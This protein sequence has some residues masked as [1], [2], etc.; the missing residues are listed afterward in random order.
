[1]RNRYLDSDITRL[2]QYKFESQYYHKKE[3]K[4]QLTNEGI[5]FFVG[6]ISGHLPWTSVNS[7]EIINEYLY[8]NTNLI[9][10]LI[11]ARAFIKRED[12][13]K[14]HDYIS[15]KLVEFEKEPKR[16]T[17]ISPKIINYPIFILISLL[18]IPIVGII[19]LRNYTENSTVSKNAQKM[20]YSAIQEGDY[21]DI[22]DFCT[23]SFKKEVSQDELNEFLIKCHDEIGIVTGTSI[24]K[25]AY[26]TKNI[27]GG[28]R[29]KKAFIFMDL[30]G[31]NSAIEIKS[32]F[33]K[34]GNLWLL[35][36]FEIKSK[37]LYLTTINDVDKQDLNE[38]V[39]FDNNN[40]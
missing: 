18:F 17:E 10:F 7:Y 3:K 21:T 14:F 6:D 31:G 5:D 19:F 24:T 36:G 1:M 25:T 28:G 35:N 37:G 38:M 27:K 23:L 20:W 11:P 16:K 13:L 9:S 29:V 32:C 22:Y 34:L 26:V 12:F 30:I 15:E 33:W 2:V 8:V 4:I 39:Y 40:K